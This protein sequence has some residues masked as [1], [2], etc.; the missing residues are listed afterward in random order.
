[1]V[2]G[3]VIY[4]RN[5]HRVLHRGQNLE[6]RQRYETAMV[7]YQIVVEKFSLSYAVIK[8][9]EGLLRI[10]PA[11]QDSDLPERIGT[12]FLEEKLGSRF[13][14]YVMYWL[15]FMA[16]PLCAGLLF[17]VFITR[18]RRAGIAFLAILLMAMAGFGFALELTWYGLTSSHSLTDIA[19]GILRKSSMVFGLTYTFL[20]VT[21]L[22]MLT[23]TR[24]VK[25]A[26]LKI[27]PKEKEKLKRSN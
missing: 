21:A 22:M 16:W 15:P 25:K 1:L 9:K 13:S 24:K 26:S 6:N 3:F 12:T 27:S 14:P 4:E 5:A 20:I 2:I 11:L 18:L 8:A 7:A 19:E 17:L 10:E 23:A